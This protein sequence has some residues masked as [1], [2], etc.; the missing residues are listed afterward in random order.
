LA[1]DLRIER[2]VSGGPFPVVFFVH[3]GGWITGS[4]AHFCH[5]SFEL[6][7]HGIAGVRLEYRW[8]IHGAKYPEAIS[9]VMDAINYIRERADELN[10]DFRRVGLAGGSAG[11]HL[12]AIAAQLTP[13]CICYDGYN[14]LY[15]AYDRGRSHFGSGDYTGTTE[16][17]KKA[18]SA[19]YNLR[20]PPPHTWLYHGTED[21]TVDLDVA[22]RFAAAIRAKGGQAELLV[23]EGVGHTF[24]GS[25]PYLTAT[26]RALLDHTSTV[27]GMND[28]KPVLSDYALP[29]LVAEHPDEFTLVGEWTSEGNKRAVFLADGTV[30]YTSGQKLQWIESFGNLYVVWASGHY[31]KIT[32][33]D[34][35]TIAIGEQVFRQNARN[36]AVVPVPRGQED[37]LIN[38]QKKVANELET[39]DLTKV[40]TVFIGDS[41]TQGWIEEGRV[42]WD[43]SFRHAL[44]LGVSGDRTEHVLYRLIQKTDG[45]TIGHL[46]DPRLRPKRI[47]LMIG[48]NNLF[49]HDPDQ[50]VQGIKAVRDR[51]VALEPQAQIILCSVL[52][53]AD[54]ERNRNLVMPVNSAI[55]KLD[56]V[57]WLDLYSQMVDEQG[58]QRTELFKD[59]VHLSTQG[60]QIW[61]DR[62][63]ALLAG[64][65]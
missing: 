41:I 7:K 14:G 16:A 54:E 44:N 17:E 3:G 23:Y 1:L 40:D 33:T 49:K 34:A 56:G 31:G 42:F 8:Q 11:G 9:D 61:Y 29:P 57:Y 62:L 53:T 5:Q 50:I 45:G 58:R 51:L 38:R 21:Q 12:S 10:I 32:V 18:A 20:Q 59:Q 64:S 2:P 43:K 15:D 28:Q 13:E 37:W 36:P 48:T 22:Q 65:Y 60:Y 4:K 63:I 46:D 52:P 35:G 24:F 55:W 26:T 47:V 30:V 6:A 39:R 19:L 27:F 25:E